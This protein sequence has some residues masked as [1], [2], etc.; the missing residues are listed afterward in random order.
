MAA[1]EGFLNR[2]SRRRRW[3]ETA[4]CGSSRIVAPKR[5]QIPQK[6]TTSG[7]RSPVIPAQTIYIVAPSQGWMPRSRMVIAR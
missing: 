4:Y 7:N 1:M 6:W 3:M 5:G 2:L